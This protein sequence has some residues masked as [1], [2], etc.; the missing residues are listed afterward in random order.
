MDFNFTEEQVMLRD[1][2]K[3]YLDKNYDFEARQALLRSGAAWSDAAWSQLADLGLLSLPFPEEA[4]GLG[5][6][7]VDLVPVAEAFGEHLTVEPWA[8]SRCWRAAR[9]LLASIRALPMW[10]R[11][12]LSLLSPGTRAGALPRRRRSRSTLLH[13]VMA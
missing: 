10:R 13:K 9:W 3:R 4:G 5:G 2:V 1:G 11:A 8:F 6:S 12:Q 7:V